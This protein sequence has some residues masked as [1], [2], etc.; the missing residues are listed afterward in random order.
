VVRGLIAS[1]GVVVCLLAGSGTAT[2]ADTTPEALRV[3]VLRSFPHDPAAFTQGLELDGARLIESTGL[4]GRSSLREVVPSTGTV[5]RRHDLPSRLFG[6]GVTVAGDRI[7]QLTWREGIGLVYERETFRPL[8]TFPYAGEGWGIC[9]DGRHLVTSDGSAVLT[10]RD[11]S[12]YRAVRRV[13][14]T[15]G[16]S[17]RARA[18]LPQGP[19]ELLNE[20]ECVGRSVYANVWHTDLIVR[21]DPATGQVRAVIDASG[22]LVPSVAERADVLNGIAYDRKRRT[23]LL[24]GKL[25][26]RLFEVRFV[27]R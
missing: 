17:A 2:P 12:S 23:F 15:A 10:F 4:H 9:F 20:L 16:G 27:A 13:T 19:V 25:W 7:V 14:V 22:L 18:G 1:A 11:P 24:T 26:P 8:R 5:L 3:K 6:E 21:I